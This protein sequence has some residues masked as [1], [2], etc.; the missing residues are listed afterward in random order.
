MAKYMV[1]LPAP[2]YDLER[3]DIRFFID[4]PA[5]PSG[6]RSIDPRQ[7]HLMCVGISPGDFRGNITAKYR[8]VECGGLAAKLSR[9]PTHT[10][11]GSL[12]IVREPIEI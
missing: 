6:L 7:R 1:W 3:F 2:E 5:H 11:A 10:Q 9:I 8:T 4:N 12:R